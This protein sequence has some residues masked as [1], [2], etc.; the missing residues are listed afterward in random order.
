M[1]VCVGPSGIGKQA[2]P[3][4]GRSLPPFPQTVLCS[5]SSRYSTGEF[6]VVQ[7][8]VDQLP[9]M[10]ADAAPDERLD[11]GEVLHVV[12]SYAIVIKVPWILELTCARLVHRLCTAHVI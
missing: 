10:L 12:A 7:F 1:V 4:G 5:N 6:L 3:L 11:L 2:R 9:L 8:R